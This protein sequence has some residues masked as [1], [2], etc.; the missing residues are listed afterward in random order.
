MPFVRRGS[1]RLL[2]LALAAGLA[3]A[4]C[5]NGNDDT[6][7]ASAPPSAA[8]GSTAS[9]GAPGSLDQNGL[10]ACNK[11][12]QA[13]QITGDDVVSKAQRTRL[14]VQAADSARQSSA[15]QIKDVQSLVAGATTGSGGDALDRVRGICTSLGWTPS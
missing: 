2:P 13:A 11:V 14:L 12:N 4:G 1:L 8:T 9:A 3:L 5:G 7:A 15:Q 6:P 10:D